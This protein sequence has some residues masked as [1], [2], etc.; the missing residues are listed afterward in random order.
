MYAQAVLAHQIGVCSRPPQPKGP[1]HLLIFPHRPLL[2]E[3]PPARYP[4]CKRSQS[5]D[6]QEEGHAG[7]TGPCI[8]DGGELHSSHLAI[9]GFDCVACMCTLA[10][11]TFSASVIA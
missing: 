2:R 7:Y 3:V 6:L 10:R 1:P 5:S 11:A 8:C 9:E 4:N